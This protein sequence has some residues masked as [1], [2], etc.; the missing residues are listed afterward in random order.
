MDGDF[1]Y[2][3][4]CEWVLSVHSCTRMYTYIQHATV[5][6]AVHVHTLYTLP[7]AWFPDGS[8]GFIKLS[9]P[10]RHRHVSALLDPPACISA[11]CSRKDTFAS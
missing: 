11:A 2:I 8:S 10:R 7:V 4:K 1:G 9:S 3:Y 6:T 5:L